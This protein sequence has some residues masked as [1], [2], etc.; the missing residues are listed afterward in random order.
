[1]T[2]TPGKNVPP[3]PAAPG[4]PGPSTAPPPVTSPLDSLVRGEGRKVR[5]A[6]K[7]CVAMFIGMLLALAIAAVVVY[8]SV[9]QSPPERL[10]G[11]AAVVA[12][13]LIPP[14]T[15]AVAYILFRRRVIGSLP[16]AFRLMGLVGA[17]G[18]MF[19]ALLALATAGVVLIR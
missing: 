17:L 14:A 5:N 10:H 13:V 3:P 4:R 1:M 16:A 8:Y 19:T 15:A 11:I 18:L 9:T 7:V 12:V 2:E 6:R